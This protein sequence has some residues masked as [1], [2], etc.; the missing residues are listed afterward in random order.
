LAGF[1]ASALIIMGVA[2]YVAL[3]LSGGLLRSKTRRVDTGEYERLEHERGLAVQALRELEFDREM[4]KLGDRDYDT[5]HE[6]LERRALDAMSAIEK[7]RD[8]SG[9]RAPERVTVLAA[10]AARRVE[11]PVAPG[12][13]RISFCPNCGARIAAGANFCAECGMG[14]RPQGRA[15]GW[16]D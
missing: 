4:G 9:R 15:T 5:L 10:R 2:L 6:R 8:T 11:S 3:P 16:T 7:L 13:A 12:G 1:I 14:L